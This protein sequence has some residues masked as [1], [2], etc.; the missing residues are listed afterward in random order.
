MTWPTS[1]VDTTTT[2]AGT[3]SPALARTTFA[4]LIAKFNQLR[5][6]VTTFI[7]TFLTSAN[8]V[9]ARSALNAAA[10]GA[11][12]DIT[13]L[14][15]GITGIKFAPTQTPSS[16]VNTLDDYEE[17][18]W[19]PA[20]TFGGNA[21]G[22][23]HNQQ[24]GRYIKIG[25]LVMVTFAIGISTKGSSTGTLF[26]GGLPFAAATGA[27]EPYGAAGWA[28]TASNISSLACAVP[29]G[30]QVLYFR[31]TTAPTSVGP[32]NMTD[33]DAAN[34]MSLQGSISYLAAA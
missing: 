20:M 9:A 5:N 22:L 26:V 16:D 31:R 11:N 2:D 8:D 24:T 3:D 10:N 18:T 7:A 15:A 1:D 19:T 34:F 17:G 13:S 29:G 27:D 30:S 32:T 12:G 4:D 14:T 28:N 6:H 25:R 33:A 21:V 23:A